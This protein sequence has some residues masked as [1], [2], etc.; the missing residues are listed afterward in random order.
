MIPSKRRKSTA[1]KKRMS[2]F[3]TKN[4]GADAKARGRLN[5][6]NIRNYCQRSN[7]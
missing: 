4:F 3:T 6:Y 5:N 1:G 2:N 7:D